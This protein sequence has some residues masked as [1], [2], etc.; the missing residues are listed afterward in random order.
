[1]EPG[2]IRARSGVRAAAPAGGPIRAAAPASARPHIVR[3][4][5]RHNCAGVSCPLRPGGRG[6]EGACGVWGLVSARGRPTATHHH[7]LLL[8]PVLLQVK[9]EQPGHRLDVG[10]GC[11]APE[12]RR[13]YVTL[14]CDPRE[15]AQVK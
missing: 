3:Y 1:M 14:L 12:A 11:L 2:A 10:L 7:F 8:L 13:V 15:E 9:L 4:T 5:K 6:E